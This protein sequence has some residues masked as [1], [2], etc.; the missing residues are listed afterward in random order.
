MKINQKGVFVIAEAGVNHNGSLDLAKQLIEIAS[1]CGADAVKFQTFKT[2][3]VISRHAPKATYQLEATGKDETQFD[4]VKKLE[5]D[6]ASYVELS[7]HSTKCGIQFLSTPFD[8]SSLDFLAYELDVPLIKLPS[9]EITNA[10]LLL[11]AAATL[12]PIILS[13]GMSTLAEVRTALGVLAYGYLGLKD[14]PSI[15]SFVNAY[16][17]REGQE[18]LKERIILLHA[19]SAYPTPYEDVNLNAMDMLKEEFGL[20]VGLSDHT[21]GISVPA[22]AA[23]KG[24]VVVE[25]HFTIDNNLPGPDHK[26]SLG[27]NELRA[28]V[29][30]IRQVEQS[31]GQP[32]KL[33]TRSELENRIVARKSLVAARRIKVGE[34]FSEE[35][36]TAKRPGTGISPMHYWEW[37]GKLAQRTYKKDDI[38]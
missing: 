32:D 14:K 16:S 22:A 2:D 19:T 12:K 38:I 37:L 11:K 9:G 20:S 34:V 3:Q 26:A 28:M 1:Q 5:L 8:L 29:L 27:P 33:P 35:N 23:A 24:A 4:M 18:V 30:S 25:K 7:K 15:G 13:T 36:L 6:F 31:L 21:L 10:P 17:S